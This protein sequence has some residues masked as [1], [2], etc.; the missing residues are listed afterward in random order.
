[1]GFM[2][3]HGDTGAYINIDFCGFRSSRSWVHTFPI[4]EKVMASVTVFPKP[5]I[6][7]G[8]ELRKAIN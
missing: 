8:L 6:V 4:M 7:L 1:M 2:K 5:K 3:H